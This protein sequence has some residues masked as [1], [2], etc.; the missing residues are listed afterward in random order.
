MTIN[1]I[2]GN[3]YYSNVRNFPVWL[4]GHELNDCW[5]FHSAFFLLFPK[6]SQSP[7]SKEIVFLFT[8]SYKPLV[9]FKCWEKKPAGEI[10]S[11]GQIKA[12]EVLGQSVEITR[13]NNKRKG[14]LDDGARKVMDAINPSVYSQFIMYRIGINSN[15]FALGPWSR[16]LE[17]YNYVCNTNVI[18]LDN[19]ERNRA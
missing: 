19:A 4:T 8:E 18:E 14:N 11:A 10:R 15:E 16:K 13:S 12:S 9:V 17:N 6:G 3:S 1:A 5:A 7:S 2:D